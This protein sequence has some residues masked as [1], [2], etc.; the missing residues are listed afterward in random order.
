M[1]INRINTVGNERGNILVVTLIV[2][3]AVS[4]IGATLAMVSSMDLKISGNQ[5]KTTRAFFVAEAGMSEAIHRLSLPNPTTETVGAW[6]GNIAIGDSEPYDPDWETRVFLAQPSAVAPSAGSVVTTGTIQDP[7]L[8]YLDYSEASGTEGIMTIKHKWEDLN[9]NST[10]EQNEIVRYDPLQIPPENFVSGFPVEIVT[11]TGN[12]A[13][14]VRVIQ[15]EVTKR[16]MVARTLGSLYVDKA[17]KLTGNCAFCGYNHSVN[18]PPGTQPNAC[19]AW[20]LSSGSLPGV[21]STGDDVK[22]Q[23]S[24]DV[25][26]S[27][28]PIDKSSTNPFYSLHEVLG[29][30]QP[31]VNDILAN[32]DN[33]SITNP[34]NGVTYINGDANIASNLTGQGLIYVTGDLKASGNFIY[35]GLIYVEGDVK[36]TG[37]PWVLGSMVIKGTSD[38]N[39]S[40]GNAAVLYSKDAISQSLS[41]MMP[42]IVLSWREM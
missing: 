15:A 20:H 35:R 19:A 11:V 14:G 36:F 37:T 31:E 40:A 23:G 22:T 32:A 2:L 28:M 6:S 8:P 1:K 3:F 39:F 21:T 7:T 42:C 5:R 13:D 30:S 10:R 41:A 33:T 16:T 18:T 17:V 29:L 27:P 25:A 4:M 12:S 9:G 34:L 38:F 24:A 26:G